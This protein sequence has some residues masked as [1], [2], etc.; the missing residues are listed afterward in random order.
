MPVAG[1]RR[2]RVKAVKP[3]SLWLMVNGPPASDCHIGARVTTENSLDF[4][5]RLQSKVR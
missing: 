2:I 5:R 4:G 1:N 3:A